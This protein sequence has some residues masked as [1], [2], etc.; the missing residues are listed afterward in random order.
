MFVKKSG[1]NFFGLCPF[2]AEKSAS[3]SVNTEK[4]IYHCF[5]CGVGGSVFNFIMQIENLSFPEAVAFLANI[6]NIDMPQDDT[7]TDRKRLLAINRDA[8]RWFC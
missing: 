8:A 2:H 7:F 3:F 6:A 5:G 4:Q 1:A